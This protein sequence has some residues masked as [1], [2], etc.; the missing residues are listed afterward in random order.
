MFLTYI[1]KIFN[2]GVDTALIINRGTDSIKM[3]GCGPLKLADQIGKPNACKLSSPFHTK[4]TANVY[5]TS[6]K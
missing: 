4:V 6:Q 3:Q 5:S 2:K 1:S